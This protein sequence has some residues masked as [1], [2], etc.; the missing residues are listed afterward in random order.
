[1]TPLTEQLLP[2]VE[3]LERALQLLRCDDDDS[4]IELEQS[5]Q[6]LKTLAYTSATTLEF[7]FS[8]MTFEDEPRYTLTEKGRAYLARVRT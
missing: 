3:A 6:R 2:L 7:D 8:K 1:M 4:L 5:I